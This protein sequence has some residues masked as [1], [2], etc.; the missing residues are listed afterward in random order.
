MAFVAAVRRVPVESSS[1]A[2]VGYAAKRQ[3]LE[4]EFRNGLVY[5]YFLVPAS[6]HRELMAASSKGAF[7]NRAV[8]D[9]YPSRRV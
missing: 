7:F 6:V 1:L 2:S 4:V 5:E 8:R 3:T 9:L